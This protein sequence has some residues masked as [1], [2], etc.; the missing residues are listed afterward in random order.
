MQKATLALAIL[1]LTLTAYNT[2]LTT[3]ERYEE[4][5]PQQVTHTAPTTTS[6]IHH[7]D[8]DSPTDAELAH[9]ELQLLNAQQ[10]NADW[11]FAYEVQESPINCNDL[12]DTVEF[13]SD[14][15][16]EHVGAFYC[17]I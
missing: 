6:G 12:A 4:A 14:A 17:G 11:F 16:L 8:F 13:P 3:E 10:Q 1:I 15:V 5:Q 9:A 7:S 2:N